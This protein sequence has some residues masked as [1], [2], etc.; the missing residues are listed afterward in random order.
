VWATAAWLFHV[1]IVAL[2]AIVFAYPLSGVAFA[3]LFRLE[4][5]VAVVPARYRRT[6]WSEPVV[7]ASAT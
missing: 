2:M 5:L 6:G 3:P 1:G 7:V 4:R